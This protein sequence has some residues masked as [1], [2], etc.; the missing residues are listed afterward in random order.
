M[1]YGYTHAY[2]PEAPPP[3]PPPARRRAPTE[4]H[5][6]AALLYFTAL[7]LCFAA[8]AFAAATYAD[9]RVAGTDL[10]ETAREWG[11]QLGLPMAALA[12]VGALAAFVVGRRVHKGRRWARLFVIVVSLFGL[13]LNGFMLVRTGFADPLT[14][15]VLPVLYLALLNTRAARDFFAGR[16]SFPSSGPVM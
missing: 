14:G 6:A 11:A 8:V 1:A 9:G 12:V 5:L 13:G 4:V 16:Q 7:F 10:P 3:P 15:L 2:P